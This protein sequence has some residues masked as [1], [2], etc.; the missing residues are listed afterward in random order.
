MRSLFES[1]DEPLD[2]DNTPEILE[3]RYDGR[4][5][6]LQGYSDYAMA[7][8]RLRS[9]DGAMRFRLIYDGPLGTQG[10]NHAFDDK[11]NI[12]N[13][14]HSQLVDLWKSHPALREWHMGYYPPVENAQPEQQSHTKDWAK[15]FPPINDYLPLVRQQIGMIC[16]LD[17]L[18]LRQTP[19]GSI[20]SQSGD[21]DNRIK[22]L[23]DGLQMPQ[24]DAEKKGQTVDDKPFHCLLENDALITSFAV[25]SDRLLARKDDKQNHAVLVIDVTV[26]PVMTSWAAVQ[27]LVD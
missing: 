9:P 15:Q 5:A 18:F 3:R 7:L 19:K 1:L 11:W 20:I 17:I 12:R 13:Q 22:V 25:R 26:A 6:L 27:F 24:N 8:A 14:L 10:S 4:F 16:S 21:L 2:S 23:F